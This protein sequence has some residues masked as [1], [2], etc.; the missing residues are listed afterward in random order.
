V[1]SASVANLISQEKTAL[2]ID[3]PVAIASKGA[4]R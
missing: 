2:L 3:H 4:S 1:T